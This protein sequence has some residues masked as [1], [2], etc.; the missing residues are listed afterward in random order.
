MNWHR[1][2]ACYSALFAVAAL[3]LATIEQA[4]AQSWRSA[5]PECATVRVTARGEQI[6]VQNPEVCP[7][8]FAPS[9][10]PVD[11]TINP[12]DHSFELFNNSDQDIDYLHIFPTSDLNN[13]TIYGGNRALAPGRAWSVTLNQGCNYNVL[14]EY[15]DGT[16]DFHQDVDTCSYRGMR[17]Q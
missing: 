5:A 11:R 15:E 14:V 2:M 1:I 7:V 3:P 6:L 10:V 16:Q 4:N 9:S 8:L 17:L 13:V 12:D